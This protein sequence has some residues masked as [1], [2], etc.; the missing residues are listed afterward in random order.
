MTRKHKM[1]EVLAK[2][3]LNVFEPI[4]SN[5]IHLSKKEWEN[6]QILIND[7]LNRYQHLKNKIRK[8]N[9]KSKSK[10]DS[11]KTTRS[12]KSFSKYF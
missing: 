4:I 12:L 2:N 5:V 9:K 8:I 1:I 6:D 10:K 7:K 11:R 3:N